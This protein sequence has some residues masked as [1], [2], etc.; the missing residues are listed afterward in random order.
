[1]M[2]D[3]RGAFRGL[4]PTL[5]AGLERLGLG[6][7]DPVVSQIFEYLSE[8]MIWNRRYSLVRGT[9]EDLVVRHVL[10]SLGPI[11]AIRRELAGEG[12]ALDLGSGAGFPGVP[13]AVA[14]G[15]PMVLLDRS[16]RAVAFLRAAV[17]RL[18][19]SHCR[20]IEGDATGISDRFPVVVSR[21]LSPGGR[22]GLATVAGTLSP[23]G[24]AIIYS[25]TRE[26]AETLLGAGE[27]I[28]ASGEVQAVTV[29]F[30][31]A[32]RHIVLF[33]LPG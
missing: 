16:Q 29:P 19:I 6:D 24:R 25:G 32:P 26:S 15:I 3:P 30:L 11:D 10:D 21:A 27:G 18:G 28:F 8:L 14:G 7:P 31:E 5:R 22:Q 13:L 4:E 1:M 2:H 12:P 23:K 20:V 33:R 17:A 9:P